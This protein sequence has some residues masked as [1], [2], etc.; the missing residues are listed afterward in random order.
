MSSTA[1]ATELIGAGDLLQPWAPGDDDL[2]DRERTWTV[3]VPARLAHL[4]ADFVERIR[5]WPQVTE[6]L[7]RRVGRRT[8][9]LN[10]QRA[11]ASQPRLEIRLVLLLWHFA[12]RWG[13]VES[14]GIRV[15]LPLTHRMLGHLVGAERPSVSHALSRLA[16]TG[17]LVGDDDGW[18]L[19]GTLEQHL[20][21]LAHRR[22]H[23]PEHVVSDIRKHARS[24]AAR[25]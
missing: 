14:G 17:L 2:V 6:A 10:L 12:S 24:R 5:P 25:A 13:K 8:A 22:E 21:T 1:S 3:L 15:P 20:R 9:D 18:H 7:L 11:I 4:D 19:S 16:D 23:T